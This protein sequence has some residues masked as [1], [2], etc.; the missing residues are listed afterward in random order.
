MFLVGGST[1]TK[2]GLDLV[3]KRQRLRRRK[4]EVKSESEANHIPRPYEPESD[5]E[6]EQEELQLTVSA[7]K[8]DEIKI[9]L[10]KYIVLYVW[11]EYERDRRDYA[12]QR[13]YQY[14]WR[15]DRSD[16]NIRYIRNEEDFGTNIVTNRTI[17][18]DK[19]NQMREEEYV[20][21]DQKIG[22]FGRELIEEVRWY[23]DL[24]GDCTDVT[25]M[26]NTT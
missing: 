18:V 19:Y 20:V 22:F 14:Q 1:I 25:P 12:C 16:G 11:T 21:T 17:A 3:K 13:L 4:E 6:N 5:G 24:T 26:Q 23:K 15:Y 10:E 9:D 7:L 2:P 8:H